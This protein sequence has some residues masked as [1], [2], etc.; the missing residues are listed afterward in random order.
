MTTGA[1]NQDVSQENRARASGASTGLVTSLDELVGGHP[2]T[3]RALFA[4]GQAADPR[5]LGE[6]PRGRLLALEQA[7]DVNAL[8]R[9]IVQ[10]IAGPLPWRGKVFHADGSGANVVLGREVAPFTWRTEAS[11]VDGEPA[12]VLSYAERP[13]PLAAIHDELRMVSDTIAIGPIVARTFAGHVVIGW[14]GL[15]RASI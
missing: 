2:D 15:T 6:A 5:D 4:H 13:W 10:A 1:T 11:V 9:P 12:L 7:R 14:F 3:L 8:A